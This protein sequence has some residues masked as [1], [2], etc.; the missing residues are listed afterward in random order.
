MAGE[1]EQAIQLEF[2]QFAQAQ[3]GA[4]QDGQAVAGERVGEVGDGGHHVAVVI[5][6]ERTGQRPIQPWDV[7]GVQQPG[8]RSFGP[9]PDREII[10]ERAQVDH[11]PFG[12]RRGDRSVTGDPAPPGSTVVVAQEPFQVG[13]GQ[14]R[15]PT[16]LGVRGG[17]VLAEH[18]QAVRAQRQ[19]ARSQRG[20]HQREVAQRDLADLRL[21]DVRGE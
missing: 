18:D 11:G 5:G 16:H 15:Q 10:E 6:G 17:E 9:A 13:A 7:P 4:A 14:L 12:H 2:E 1:V 20:R 3:P 8:R 19:G 21:R